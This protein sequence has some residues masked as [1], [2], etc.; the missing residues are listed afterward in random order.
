[1]LIAQEVAQSVVRSLRTVVSVIAR[2]DSSL[3]DQVRRAASSV[4]L[5]VAEGSRRV[6][7]D[8]LYLYRVAAGSAAE[9]LAA[10]EIARC[11]GYISDEN[12]ATSRA[13]LDRELALLF[14][15]TRRAK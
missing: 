13:L 2:H 9:T 12:L 10:L 11:W 3:A 1:M 5:N 4:L 15:L 14:G 7:R 8:R 6:G